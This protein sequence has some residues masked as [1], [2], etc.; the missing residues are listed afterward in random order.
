MR[1]SVAMI[2]IL[3]DKHTDRAIYE[4]AHAQ[5]WS[6]LLELR[7]STEKPVFD[8]AVDILERKQLSQ[9]DPLWE[10]N[11]TTIREAIR[12]AR[13]SLAPKPETLTQDQIRKGLR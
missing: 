2:E 11:A 9:L 1:F 4:T 5:A 10:P 3:A 13:E 12:E 7:Y 8:A 6:A